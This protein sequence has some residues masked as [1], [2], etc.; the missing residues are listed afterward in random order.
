MSIPVI[1]M[2]KYICNKVFSE[3]GFVLLNFSEREFTKIQKDFKMLET[4]IIKGKQGIFY[5]IKICKYYVTLTPVRV[6]V[7]LYV[8]TYISW[9]CF[10]KFYQTKQ[11]LIKF[12][13]SDF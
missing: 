3:V 8:L 2:Y 6:L 9:F 4:L 10:I 7:F 13:K 5:F 12:T 1:Y 11:S